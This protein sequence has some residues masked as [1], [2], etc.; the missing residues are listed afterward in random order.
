MF[1]KDS[2][3]NQSPEQFYKMNNNTLAKLK[4][5]LGRKYLKLLSKETGL[6]RSTVFAVMRGEWENEI[7]ID[8]AYDILEKRAQRD[9]GI[10][11]MVG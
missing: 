5:K 10:K 1:S 4:T 7:I 11:K 8:A 6:S 9:E 3:S 2:E